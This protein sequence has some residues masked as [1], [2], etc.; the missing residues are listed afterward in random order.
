MSIAAR[1]RKVEKAAGV[2][3]RCLSCRDHYIRYG[4]EIRRTAPNDLLL[5][6]CDNCGHTIKLIYSGCT[7]R[8]RSVLT[9]AALDDRLR[10]DPVKWIASYAWIQYMPR[11]LEILRIGEE[12]ETRL[13]DAMRSDKSAM[14]QVNV[15]NEYAAHEK[16]LEVA[17]NLAKE[18]L[19]HQKDGFWADY[20]IVYGTLDEVR[21]RQPEIND[22]L[23]FSFLV[24]AE[25]EVF[26]WGEKSAETL[27]L[28]GDRQREIEEEAERKR[29]EEE[30]RKRDEEFKRRD[31]EFLNR[32]RALCGLPPLPSSDIHA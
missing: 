18:Q 11:Y 15:L 28:V 5:T 26:M 17:Y 1:L 6:V 8:E 30:K 20:F 16:R 13:R 25:M 19:R 21:K 12:E 23:L 3:G 7:E 24:M 29:F 2:G 22:D 4:N 9:A 32:S 10:S 31:K 27:K 14:R